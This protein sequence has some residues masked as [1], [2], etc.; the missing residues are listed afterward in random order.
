MRMHD[1]AGSPEA[2]A[3]PAIPRKERSM[4]R[5]SCERCGLVDSRAAVARERKNDSGGACPRCGGT[6]YAAERAPDAARR[7]SVVAV[8]SALKGLDRPRSR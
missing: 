8:R 4:P 1:E 6:R 3:P 5:L 2:G 7:S